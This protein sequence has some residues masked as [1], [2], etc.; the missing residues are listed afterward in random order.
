MEKIESKIKYF[1]PNGY[2]ENQISDDSPGFFGHSLRFVLVFEP[3][4]QP[5]IAPP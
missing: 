2:E 4:N 1:H 5:S 3:E